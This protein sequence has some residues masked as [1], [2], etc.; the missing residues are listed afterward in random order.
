MPRLPGLPVVGVALDLLRDPLGTLRR[1]ERT[2][3]V[4]RMDVGPPGWRRVVYGVFHP[5][6]VERVLVH[7]PH[8]LT[9][10]APQYQELRAA[11]GDGLF[12]SEG[13]RWHRQRRFVAPV[14]TRRRVLASYAPVAV[15]EMETVAARWGDGL[16]GRGGGE[17]TVDV[18]AEMV[19]F[20]VRFIVR[21]LLGVDV[22]DALPAL[23]AAE[24]GFNQ[25]VRRRSISPRPLP[26][27]VPTG[28]N[29]RLAAAIR[30]HRAL[31][32]GIVARR[33]LVEAGG[34]D[35]LGLLL[36]ARD[37]GP[38]GEEA[39]SDTEITDQV[40]AFLLAGHE[41]TATVLALALLRLAADPSWQQVL[42]DEI[43]TV[44]GDRPPC[45]EDLPRLVWTDRV[46]RE[47]LRLWPSAPTT[48]RLAPDGDV[49]MGHRLPPG[50]VVLVS[51][52]ATHH[53]PDL[54]PEPDRFDPARFIDPLPGGHR[55]AW[56]PFGAGAHACVGAQLAMVEAVLGLTVL[57]Q[58]FRLSADLTEPPLDV[59]IVLRPA[60]PL[61]VR[62]SPR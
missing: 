9:K 33:R 39:L 24:P 7:D 8:R 61:P 29:R 26:M 1:A 15:E 5:D 28:T 31:V 16:G 23:H 30:D 25:G 43:D 19:G 62:V 27:W 42:H 44:V 46:V 36:A 17:R 41:T 50:A 52:Y 20:T 59:G 13:E 18:H 60:G 51:P 2:G 22:H 54:W 55:Y 6:G 11:L 37:P 49:V 10:Q 47:V 48:V 56:I 57:L 58:R 4:V 35:L 3:P 34:E 45:A 40:L 21:V 14:L 38:D 12:T 53:S 32:D